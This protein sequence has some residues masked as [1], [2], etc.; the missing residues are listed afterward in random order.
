MNE[1]LVLEKVQAWVKNEFSTDETGHDFAHMVR[2]SRL[3]RELAEKEASEPFLAEIIGLVHDVYDHKLT[4]D[5][6]REQRRLVAFL[7]EQ[8]FDQQTIT[9]M[10]DAIDSVS[11]SK[12]MCA[13]TTLAKVV[14]DADRLDAIGAIGIIR[15]LTYGQAK[16]RPITET[17]QHFHD[18]LF[19]IKAL[20][21]T[22]YAKQLATTRDEVMHAFYDAYEQET[23]L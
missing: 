3:S 19:K 15:T 9:R 1:R 14:Q 11:F 6:S 7:A 18:K 23:S 21:N 10:V 17:M 12:G 4:E 22:S 20:L 2:V 16:G 8:G 5:P 13:A